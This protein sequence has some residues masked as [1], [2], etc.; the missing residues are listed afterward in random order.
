MSQ[1]DQNHDTAVVSPDAVPAAAPAGAVA[2]PAAPAAPVKEAVQAGGASFVGVFFEKLKEQSFTIML[3]CA[4]VYYQHHLWQTDKDALTKEVDQKEERILQL[5]EREHT[6]T[7]E[8][9]K[10]LQQQRD[11]FIESIKEQAAA[12]RLNRQ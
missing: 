12:C 3:M 1:Q 5:V 8:R 10:L 9:E 7:L 11:Q 2:A 6:H 4:V